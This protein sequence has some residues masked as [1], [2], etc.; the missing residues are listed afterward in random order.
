MQRTFNSPKPPPP[1]PKATRLEKLLMLLLLVVAVDLG[2]R[3]VMNYTERPPE[4]AA[5]PQ[6]IVVQSPSPAAGALVANAVPVWSNPPVSNV[7]PSAPTELPPPPPMA[8][9]PRAGAQPSSNFAGGGGESAAYGS[10]KK[11]EMW[12]RTIPVEYFAPGAV[13]VIALPDD[14]PDAGDG[15]DGSTPPP[16]AP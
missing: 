9:G 14:D 11:S 15:G 7:R 13:T 5:A 6:V 3:V 2:R 16:P 12:S 1:A 4:R 10:V 8:G